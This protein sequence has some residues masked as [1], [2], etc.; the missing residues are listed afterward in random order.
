MDEQQIGVKMGERIHASVMRELGLDPSECRLLI[1]FGDQLART[2]DTWAL[3]GVQDGALVTVDVQYLCLAELAGHEAPISALVGHPDGRIISGS[4]DGN[5]R[6]WAAP[7]YGKGSHST[8]QRAL[9]HP[10]THGQCL[11]V[12]KGHTGLCQTL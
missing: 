8:S 12:L 3:L 2:T 7:S 9:I 6:I 5:V 4:Y 11:A 10:S 1:R